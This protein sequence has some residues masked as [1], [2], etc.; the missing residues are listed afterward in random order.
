MKRDSDM[1]GLGGGYSAM[2]YCM[3]DELRMKNCV[4]EQM[5]YC[6]G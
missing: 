2:L 3:P 5:L 6:W 1:R 4:G